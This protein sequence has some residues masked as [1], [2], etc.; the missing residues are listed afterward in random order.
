MGVLGLQ[1]S[2]GKDGRTMEPRD[3]DGQL[4]EEWEE[5]QRCSEVQG[6]HILGLMI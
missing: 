1:T 6:V 3:G 2:W 4:I 5:V